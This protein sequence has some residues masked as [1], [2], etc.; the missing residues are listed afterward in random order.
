M[1]IQKGR[2]CLYLSVDL[3]EKVDEEAREYGMR[4]SQM[5]EYILRKHFGMLPGRH[6]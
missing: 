4:R 5:V 1:R 6:Y 3:I 2:V